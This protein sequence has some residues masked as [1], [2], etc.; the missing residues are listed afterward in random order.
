MPTTLSRPLEP[1]LVAGASSRHPA[2][3]KR[4]DRRGFSTLW[5]VLAIPLCLTVLIL[6]VDIAN[7]WLARAELENG[8]EAAAL[9]AVQEWGRAGGGDTTI[10]RA[11]GVAYAAANCVRGQP[12]SL[13]TNLD[14]APSSSNP[15][16]NLSCCPTASPPG[17]NLIFGAITD[18]AP[19][20]FDAGAPG[21]C[22]PAKVYIDVFKDNSD[23]S[24]SCDHARRFG[25]FFD[26]GPPELSIRSVSFTIP[27]LGN[28]LPQQPYFDSSKPIGV[29]IGAEPADFLNR[30]NPGAQ[31]KDVRGLN[32]APSTVDT[33]CPARQWTCPNPYGDICFTLAN[34]VVCGPCG[35]NRFRT[36][37]IHFTDGTFTSTN[38]PNTTD[39]V[40][41]EATYCALNPPALD[42]P[43]QN[44]GDA[45]WMAPVRVT[46]VFYNSLTNQT[47][48]SHTVF[49]DN[50]NPSDGYAYAVVGGGSGGF[51]PAVRAQ[52]IVPVR[53]LAQSVFGRCFESLNVLVK[54]TA[55]YDC[56]TGKSRLI[57]VE[58]FICPGPAP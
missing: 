11:V 30:S 23:C 28:S 40:R 47:I 1:I 38:D 9:A 54:T 5:L 34:Q 8:L 52:A 10:P 46:V 57:R 26:E 12:L 39:F 13:S 7:L 6:G 21:G 53:S 48:T 42:P 25:I 17:G 35:S 18:D 32:W 37:T 15:N 36:L 51:T 20:T 55:A 56:A 49:R 41:F 29:S 24:S 43:A 4:F 33:T 27:V 14:P 2:S 31:P 44:D 50:G 22:L 45:F 58:R 16:A 19:L 3:G